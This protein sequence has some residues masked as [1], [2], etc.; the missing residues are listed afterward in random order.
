M[1]LNHVVSVFKLDSEAQ[2]A[3]E[4]VGPRALPQKRSTLAANGAGR[5]PLRASA[6]GVDAWEEF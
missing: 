3:S 5:K 4:G 2:A 1:A 6:A